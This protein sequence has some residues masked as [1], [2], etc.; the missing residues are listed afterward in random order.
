M[1]K[2]EAA[3]KPPARVR[4]RPSKFKGDET[5]EQVAKLA[6]LGATDV[7]IAD[8]LGVDV[9]TLYRWKAE[10]PDFCNALKAAKDMADERVVRSLYWRACGYE[11]DEI[12]IRVVDKRIV[13]TKIRKFYPPDPTAAIFWLSN[14]QPDVWK[15]N[16]EE[17]AGGEDLAKAV[18]GLIER[19]PV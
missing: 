13:E 14:R 3:A 7:E 10:K 19:L 18:A 12:D 16:R 15:R 5:T 4:G 11:H 1:A 17:G 6:A 2:R 9:A 8:F